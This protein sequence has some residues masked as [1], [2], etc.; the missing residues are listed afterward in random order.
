MVDVGSSIGSTGGLPGLGVVFMLQLFPLVYLKLASL[1][2]ARD[3]RLLR[4]ASRSGV[5][6]D[7]RSGSGE[8][9]GG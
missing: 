1:N 9:E 8:W 4:V 6:P 5:V 3:G 7:G 2:N